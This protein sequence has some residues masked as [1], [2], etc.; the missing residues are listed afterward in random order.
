M[1]ITSLH[2]AASKKP[3]NTG[4]ANTGGHFHSM[5][6]TADINQELTD[7]SAV[8]INLMKHESQVADRDD[9]DYDRWGIATSLA[10]GLST[11]TRAYLDFFY[12][13]DDNTV[14]FVL[15]RPEAP[16]LA[17]LAMDFAS[18]LSKEY[19]DA[20]MKAGSQDRNKNSFPPSTQSDPE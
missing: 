9:V 19:A 3:T 12:Q 14:Q 5:S 20:M 17:D 4:T 16:F 13:K 10:L 1:R 11:P 2:T 8:R 18:I 7:T 15:T 6:M